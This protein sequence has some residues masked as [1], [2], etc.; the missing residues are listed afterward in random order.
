MQ[1]PKF[2][3]LVFVLATVFAVAR[4]FF[5]VDITDESNYLAHVHAF[6]LNGRVFQSDLFIQ[7]TAGIMI[8]PVVA[9]HEWLFGTEGLALLVR[10]I[11]FLWT[12][13]SAWAAYK[14]FRRYYSE[15]LG[16]LAGAL[17]LA[18]IPSAVPSWSYNTVTA[19]G[20]PL[21]LFLLFSGS[22][23]CACLGGVAAAM[24]CFAYP[25][26]SLLFGAVL[27]WMW[28]QGRRL[29]REI[30]DGG[31]LAFTAMIVIGGA[32]SAYFV[33]QGAANFPK[34]VA[35]SR[36]FA[37][38]EGLSKINRTFD[39]FQRG[40]WR[41]GFSFVL[42][43]AMILKYKKRLDWQWRRDPWILVALGIWSL[44]SSLTPQWTLGFLV[45]FPLTLLV[46][47]MFGRFERVREERDARVLRT[48]AGFGFLASAIYAYTSSNVLVNAGLA[49][50]L[51]L[52]IL[53]CE[54]VLS[55]RE[56]RRARNP[57]WLIVFVLVLIN[58]G[59][60]VWPYRDEP[61]W[62]LDAVVQEG[63]FRFIRTTKV[64]AEILQEV[65]RD[66]KALHDQGKKSIFASYA[67]PA[68]FSANLEPITGMLFLYEREWRD[69]AFRLILHRTI[70]GG[71]WPE[72]VI[73]RI[74]DNPEFKYQFE[75]F[76]LDSGR[77]ELAIAR[78]WYRIHTL[79]N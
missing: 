39:F 55:F 23:F 52:Q 29:P 60:W 18:Y 41:T 33:Y 17:S 54:A 35:F 49:M 11:F 45:Y 13:A 8:A 57:E 19:F 37:W 38:V 76:F 72:I 25:T 16:L 15:H 3:R 28:V 7:G 75:K 4:L 62:R 14:F 2:A 58:A 79:K 27:I 42:I 61:L 56:S 68:Y 67:T 50:T 36:E 70:E 71:E 66:V 5:F 63:P 48:L 74:I 34:V 59:N 9:L 6:L 43:T 21:A 20:V 47:Y 65:H 69:G 53:L 77:Y 30:T 32:V 40:G 51:P 31:K 46:F 73:T 22:T 1:S 12:F 64:R 44:F 24:S 10:F 26:T 78:K